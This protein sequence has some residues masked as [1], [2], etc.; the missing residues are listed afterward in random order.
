MSRQLAGDDL[1]RRHPAAKGAIEGALLG[2]L[3]AFKLA[4][5]RVS[6]NCGAPLSAGREAGRGV[7]PYHG[8]VCRREVAR[9]TE[10]GAELDAAGLEMPQHVPDSESAVQP[11]DDRG[12]HL[13]VLRFVVQ[14]VKQT[15]P[16]L[17]GAPRPGTFRELGA[18]VGGRQAVRRAVQQQ[19]R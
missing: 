14:F 19:Q 5:N 9:G 16:E 11:L 4:G 15:V 8:S 1:L 2:R 10:T 12:D 3:E 7:S 18:A 13:G 17:Q 6:G